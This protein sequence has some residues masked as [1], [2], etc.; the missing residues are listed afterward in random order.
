MI[1]R[2][3]TLISRLAILFAV[4]FTLAACGGGGGGGP[5]F[6]NNDDEEA[7][8]QF[9][10]YDP[11]GNA[12][13][14]ITA[15]SPGS[16]KIFVRNGGPNVVVSAETS[17]GT[18]L[19]TT[20][21]SLTDGNGV[22]TFQLEAGAENGTGIV[23]ASATVN[24]VAVTGT[25]GFNVGE[26]GLRLGYFDADGDFIE[27]QILIEPASTLSAGGNA[28]LSVVVLDKDG[29]RVS[30]AEAVR[31]TSG[32]IAGGLAT[33]N[34]TEPKSVNGQA[35]TLYSAKGCAGTDQIT[36]S[37][38]GAGAQAFGTMTIAKRE[39]N[40]V[41][42]V[43]A[44]PLLMVLR[45]TGGQN[46]EET[47]VVIFEVVDGQGAPLPGVTVQF[48]LTTYVGGLTL[49]K[50]SALSDGDGR[51][52]VTVQAGY[53]P[54]VVRVLA[55]VNDGDGNPVTTVSDLL[56]VSTGLPDQNSIS[57]AIGECDGE[58]SFVVDGAFTGDGLCRTLT[59]LMADAFNNPVVD[60]TAALFTTEYGSIV[61]SC[62]TV[63]GTCSVEW[64]SQE[65][66]FPTLTGDE[67]VVS[68][69][70]NQGVRCPSHTGVNA[71]PCPDDLG[72]IRGGRSA[73]TVTAIGEESFIDRNGNGIMDQDEQNLFENLPEAFLDDN[74]DQ[75]YTPALAECEAA[76]TGSLLCI[77]GQEEDFIDFN[78][79][80]TYD[81]N[82]NPA[83]Y[84][85]LLCP[86]EGDGIWCSRELVNVRDSVV[87]TLGDAPNFKFLLANGRTPVSNV[88]PL[89]T[90]LNLYISDT[91][92]NPPPAGAT[93]TLSTEG[94]C[95]VVPPTTTEILNYGRS[96]AFPWTVAVTAEAKDP[97]ETG[98]LIVTLDT[99]V[100]SRS[101]YYDCAVPPVPVDPCDG[102]SPLPPECPT[103]P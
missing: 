49:S 2:G 16:L 35:S 56:T 77:S 87:V 37:L 60:G 85:G 41:N 74:E 32:C 91:F 100:I 69:Y 75:V 10:L 18:L 98:Q 53:V 12:T 28:Q 81:L 80:Q 24:G 62:T 51:V 36:A 34:P 65:P 54:T 102:S 29:D 93:V 13:N 40:A 78:S 43:S 55:T 4:L 68:S 76:S 101:V 82:N 92:N 79:N 71:I 88:V 33:I 58:D 72:N 66:R 15:S 84:N 5:S 6:Y 57:L 89:N 48:S 7:S 8:F 42:F 96:G 31:F 14:S 63:A 46:R 3:A 30:T 39:T 9:T 45:G 95:E 61:S 26:N 70:D 97:P 52:S 47:S 59:V 23:S 22:A 67:Y 90:Q 99:P 103:P 86:V 44:E 73:I 17:L 38:I 21:T 83:L 11:L 64:T 50:T 94:N 27:N 20:G 19:P 1:N 25:F